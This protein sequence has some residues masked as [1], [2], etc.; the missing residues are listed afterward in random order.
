[1][2]ITTGR[3]CRVGAS[4]VPGACHV[5]ARGLGMLG[6]DILAATSSGEHGAGLM[7]NDSL[8]V[9]REYRVVITASTFAAGALEVF[10]DGSVE[11]T[12]AGTAT[13]TL[14]EYSLPVG[15]PV[16]LVAAFAE[17]TPQASFASTLGTVTG[18]LSVAAEPQASFS[19]SLGGITGQMSAGPASQASF[20]GALSGLLAVVTAG[21]FT[22]GDS[23]GVVVVRPALRTIG[24]QEIY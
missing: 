23:Q 7:F 2:P 22:Y 8:A 19:G 1:M 3:T 21:T 18:Q 12:G 14:Y 9:D 16:S 11:F 20:D 4:I 24:A 17:A 6:A 15:S 13:Q 5:G 10:E